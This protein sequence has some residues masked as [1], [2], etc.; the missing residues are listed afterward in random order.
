MFETSFKLAV[1]TDRAGLKY[2]EIY[3]T[4]KVELFS[5][6]EAEKQLVILR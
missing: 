6:V 2:K 1:W 4:G 3:H 5:K